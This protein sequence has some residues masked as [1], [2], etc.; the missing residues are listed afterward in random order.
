MM[1]ASRN[2]DGGLTAPAVA[3]YDHAVRTPWQAVAACCRD[4]NVPFISE[5]CDADPRA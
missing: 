1:N 4:L 2:P 3:L 5:A